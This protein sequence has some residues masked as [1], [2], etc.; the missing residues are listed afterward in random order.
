MVKKER[1]RNNEEVTGYKYG[2]TIELSNVVGSTPVM[3]KIDKDRMINRFTGEV[4]KIEHAKSRNDS[5]NLESL[6]HTFKNLRRLIGCNFSGGINELWITLT[7]Q[8]K[9]GKP[10]RNPKKLFKDFRLL[11]RKL[12]RFFNRELVYIAVIEPQGNGAFHLHVLLKSSDKGFLFIQNKKL[13]ELWGQGFVNVRRLKDSDNVT[14]YL[15]SYLTNVDINNLEGKLSNE[16]SKKIVKGGRLGL[17]PQHFQIYRTSRNIN[18]PTKT[19]GK[20]SSVKA[21]LGINDIDKP[22]YI[23]NFEI[24]R[25]SKKV[26][27]KTEY[28]SKK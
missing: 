7:Y 28:F 21:E 24:S 10:M 23:K 20:A 15:M 19:K 12:R 26:R 16:K 5:K 22:E 14:S 4:L 25:G 2:S 8:M 3:K 13:A 9:N 18:K 6:R 17:Y 27:V 1:I 11:I